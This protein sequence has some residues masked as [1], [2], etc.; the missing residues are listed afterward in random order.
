MTAFALWPDSLPDW[1]FEHRT[2][3]LGQGRYDHAL[4]EAAR[5]ADARDHATHDGRPITYDELRIAR[6]NA[7]ELRRLLAAETTQTAYGRDPE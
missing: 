7:T 5:R 3:G 6:P 2:A 1:I 4:L